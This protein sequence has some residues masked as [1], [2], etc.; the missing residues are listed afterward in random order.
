MKIGHGEQCY[1]YDWTRNS[2]TRYRFQRIRYILNISRPHWIWFDDHN[3]SYGYRIGALTSSRTWILGINICGWA[4]ATSMRTRNTNRT[5]NFSNGYGYL[6]H[7]LLF[8][9]Q[10]TDDEIGRLGTTRT[11]KLPR[12]ESKPIPVCFPVWPASMHFCDLRKR[13]RSLLRRS[14]SI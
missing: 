2:W 4:D 8:L 10:V 6:R 12:N 3:Y 9:M 7:R 14:T 11:S 5:N 1:E 13:I